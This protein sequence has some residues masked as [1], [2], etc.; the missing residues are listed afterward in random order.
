MINIVTAEAKQP[1]MI[2]PNKRQVNLLKGLDRIGYPYVLSRHLRSTKRLWVNGLPSLVAH[3]PRRG[4]YTVVGPN[5]WNFGWDVPRRARLEHALVI[6]ASDKSVA[7]FLGDEGFERCPVRAWGGGIDTDEFRPPANRRAGR[8][9]LVYTKHRDP[10]ELPG[11]IDVLLRHDLRPSLLMYGKYGEEGYRAALANAA[12]VVWHGAAESQ[13][14][15]LGEALSC[16]VP[17]LVC[18]YW[19]D[20]DAER[21]L[22][23]RIK[24]GRRLFD[25]AP[26]FDDRCGLK[27]EDLDEL[28]GGVQE[29][30]DRLS[31]FRPREYVLEN[32]TLE[33]CARA[34]VDLWQEWGLTFEEGLDEVCRSERPFRLPWRIAGRRI[35]GMVKRGLRERTHPPRI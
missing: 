7:Q 31:E 17:V 35:G 32:L 30:L 5:V 12:F 11:I 34:F 16:D 1:T 8:D 3:L 29:M 14:F 23:L 2:G 22:Q 21:A 28:S 19:D 4:V 27:I 15:A 20:I 24:P 18:N 10:G 13:G 26:Y 25:N 33:R 9:V 6:E